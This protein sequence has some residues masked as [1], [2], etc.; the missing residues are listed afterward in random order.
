M[1]SIFKLVINHLIGF[2]ELQISEIERDY[3]ERESETKNV[4]AM[5]EASAVEIPTEL[6]EEEIAEVSAAEDLP[7]PVSAKNQTLESEHIPDELKAE[8]SSEIES[9]PER[10]LEDILEE[11]SASAR[12]RVHGSDSFT[13]MKLKLEAMIYPSMTIG[14]SVLMRFLNPHPLPGLAEFTE[15]LE[16]CTAVFS[17]CEIE[18]ADFVQLHSPGI[19]PIKFSG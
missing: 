12:G 8:E 5:S 10:S 1:S 19:G 11:H 2:R 7:V 14:N 13:A 3:R 4:F 9:P 17:H 16:A 18:A 15:F 6:A